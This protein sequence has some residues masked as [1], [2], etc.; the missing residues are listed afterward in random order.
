MMADESLIGIDWIDNLKEAES[1]Y[2]D[3]YKEPVKVITIFLLYINKENELEHLHS[4]KYVLSENSL[5]KRDVIISLIKRYQ[6]RFNT[7]YKLLSILKYNIDLD[8][9]DIH[10]F[11][12]EDFNI[13]DKRFI[14]SEKYLNDIYFDES[15]HMFQDLN[16]LFLIFYED[17]KEVNQKAQKHSTKRVNV[18]SHKSKTKRNL[19]KKNLKITKHIS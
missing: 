15:I 14:K 11:V 6:Q 4:D 12:N 5:V 18:S 10:N 17:H 2:N 3:Y 13:S 7:S 19:I 8:P 1:I 16:A 9:M